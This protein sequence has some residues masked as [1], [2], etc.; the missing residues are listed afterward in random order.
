MRFLSIILLLFLPFCVYSQKDISVSNLNPH[1]DEVKQTILS[2]FDSFH[3]G[4]TVSLKNTIGETMVLHTVIQNEEGETIIKQISKEKL[5]DAIVSKPSGQ[6][7]N[8]QL[9][10]FTINADAKIATAWTPYEFYI[11]ET[12]IHCGVNV[13]QLYK[14]GSQWRI[15]AIADTRQRVGCH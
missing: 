4:D 7:W 5:F 12:L 6:K 13:F 8:E 3:K 15:I 2:F 1:Q 9:L 10:S 14:D 11:N